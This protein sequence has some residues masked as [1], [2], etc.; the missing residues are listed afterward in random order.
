MDAQVAVQRAAGG[1]ERAHGVAAEDDVHAVFDLADLGQADFEVAEVRGDQHGAG[2]RRAGGA[3]SVGAV[4]DFDSGRE[5]VEAVVLVGTDLTD[6]VVEA[7]DG[8]AG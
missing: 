3:V 2:A 1:F 7:G 4:G 5:L 8:A 6:E